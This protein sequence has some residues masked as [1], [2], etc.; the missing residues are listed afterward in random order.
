MKANDPF[1]KEVD[2]NPEK[3]ER[4]GLTTSNKLLS[5][6]DR[7]L[8]EKPAEDIAEALEDW[9]AQDRVFFLSQ[10]DKERFADVF[11][12]FPK[13]VKS[14]I[15]STMTQPEMVDLL[16]ELASD[17]LVDTLQEMPANVVTGLLKYIPNDRRQITNRL[18]KY[19][20]ESVGSLMSVDFVKV[21]PGTRRSEVRKKLLTINIDPEHLVEIYVVDEARKLLGVIP[22]GDL[23]QDDDE[24]IT[25]H[26]KKDIV[27]VHATEDQEVAGSLFGKY[28]RLVLPVVDSEERMV[29]IITADD[30]FE[31]M[32]DE[33]FEDF[34]RVQGITDQEEEDYLDTPVASFFKNRII[35]LLVLMVSAS[36]TGMVISHFEAVLA[37]NVL[38]TAFIPMLMDS[39]GN[40]GSQ[41]SSTVIRALSLEE[42]DPSNTAAVLWKEFRIGLVCGVVMAVVNFFRL[43]LFTSTTVPVALAV[44]LTLIGCITIAKVIGGILPLLATR[45]SQDP[46]VM[47]GPLLT[48]IADTLTL[49][50]FFTICKA[51]LGI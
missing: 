11:Y 7:E 16:D 25:K 40:A 48:T 42:V 43:I 39:S 17:E 21:R 5:P 34:T 13:E 30:I 44:S 3:N 41:S 15:L 29:G 14:S 51:L 35:W 32:S 27:T 46:A 2:M 37:A 45:L 22:L 24:D 31:V 47:A 6:A 4:N 9:Q 1:R 12:L 26:I 28:H 50:L 38:L 8:L 10:L 49:I 18:L 33:F 23:V 19:P 36:I 20:E